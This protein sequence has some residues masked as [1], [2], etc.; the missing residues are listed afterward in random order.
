M[1]YL[2]TTCIVAATL[3]EWIVNFHVFQYNCTNIF[4]LWL[5]DAYIP[6]EDRQLIELVRGTVIWVL[7]LERN[8]LC[9]NKYKPKPI[10]SL[11]AQIISLASFWYKSKMDDSFFKLTLILPFDIKDLPGTLVEHQSLIPTHGFGIN[12]RMLEAEL[13]RSG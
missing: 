3:W 10:R 4:D 6:L 13:S 5:L 2:F 1:D 11:A 8:N 9:F 12:Q 7:W